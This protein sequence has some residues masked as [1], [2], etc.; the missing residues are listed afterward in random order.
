V[1]VLAL[2][3]EVHPTLVQV[4]LVDQAL[5]GLLTAEHML[6]VVVVVLTPEQ[7]ARLDQ[8]VVAQVQLLVVILRQPQQI[9]VAVVVEVITAEPVQA[10]QAW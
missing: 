5:F 1:A 6:V 9:Q 8:V 7:V 4:A 3:V 2:L 10:D